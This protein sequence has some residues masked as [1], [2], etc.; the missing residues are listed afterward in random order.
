MEDKVEFVTETYPDGTHFRTRLDR[1]TDGRVMCCICFEFCIRE[2]LNPIKDDPDGAVED[3]CLDCAQREDN[4]RKW[5]ASFAHRRTLKVLITGSRDWPKVSVI[6]GALDWLLAAAALPKRRLVIVEGECP[7]G[8]DKMAKVWAIRQGALSEGPKKVSLE[9]IPA[10]WDT[11]APGCRPGHRKPKRGGGTDLHPGRRLD[12]CPTAGHRR[13]QD[14]VDSGADVCLAFIK[15]A[16]E[17]ATHC[18]DAARAA[19]IVTVEWTMTGNVLTEP[20]FGWRA[21]VPV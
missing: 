1:L 18:A 8:A 6:Q 2:Q 3:V 15:D 12:Y 14:M 9:G 17:G 5:R 7:S 20:P 11:C 10:D 13:N 19:G 21:L 16:S 4:V